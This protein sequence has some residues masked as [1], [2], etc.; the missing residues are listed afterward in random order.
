MVNETFNG[1][2]QQ[3]VETEMFLRTAV[4]LAAVAAA[5][6]VLVTPVLAEPMN[7]EQARRFVVGKFFSFTC[8]EGTAGSGRIFSDGSVAGVIKIQGTGPTRFMHLPPG[9]LFAK[10]ETVC[11]SV[12]GA[13]F[14][15]CFNLTR[16]SDRG[17]RGAISGFGFAYC[18][19][20]R[21]GR[22][23][24]RTA[25]TSTTPDQPPRRASIR[26]GRPAHSETAT[27]APPTAAP[28]QPVTAAPLPPAEQPAI[29]GAVAP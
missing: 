13:F 1:A 16:T 21:G 12:K 11:S 20:V 7:A 25:S 3:D 2:L 28:T 24:V 14:N 15:P 22:D 23:A 5:G 17:F 4:V 29:R 8:F 9:T 26:R 10:G 6:P 18:D 27:A 19:F